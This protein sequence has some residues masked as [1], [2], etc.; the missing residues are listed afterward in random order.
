M[1]LTMAE[2][3]IRERKD[4]ARRIK[5]H[6]QELGQKQGITITRMDWEPPIHQQHESYTL[7]IETDRGL[8]WLEL[9]REEIEDYSAGV[10]AEETDAK[11]QEVMI[12][13]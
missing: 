13:A 6:T 2:K 4:G 5:A 8:R 1:H 3:G 9:S 12:Q 11:I 7:I 10:E